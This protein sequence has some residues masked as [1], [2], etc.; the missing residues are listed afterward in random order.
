MPKFS[1]YRGVFKITEGQISI[2]D[3]AGIG[4]PSLDC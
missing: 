2:A 4:L 3:A 1:A